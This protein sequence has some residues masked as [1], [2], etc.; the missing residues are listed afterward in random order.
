M[1]NTSLNA[2]YGTKSGTPKYNGQSKA[3]MPY[4]LN[5]SKRQCLIDTP[6]QSVK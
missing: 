3:S 2:Q 6:E 1:T 4:R 5:R